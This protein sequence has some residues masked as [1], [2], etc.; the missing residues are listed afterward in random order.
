M[1]IK[2]VAIGYMQFV[3]ISDSDTIDIVNQDY[4]ISGYIIN[5][6]HC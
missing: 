2:I 5:K 4:T 3:K 1:A 6:I